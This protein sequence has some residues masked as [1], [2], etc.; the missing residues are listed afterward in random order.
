MDKTSS[1]YSQILKATSIFGGVQ[2][3]NI[4]T[5]VVRTKFVA[6]LLGPAGMG[7]VGLLSSTTDFG[8]AL[9]SFGLSTSA[10]R[11]V[12]EAHASANEDKIARTVFA[13]RRLVWITGGLG[14]LLV[15]FT[16]P[17]LSLLA[18]GHYDY[19]WAFAALSVTLLISQLSTGQQVLLQGFRK[20]RLLAKSGILASFASLIITVPLYY[21]F[22]E[23]GI[24]P[25]LLLL[26]ITGLLLSWYFARKI[27]I[28]AVRLSVKESFELG[29]HML[30]F[31]FF[32]SLSGLLSL[33]TAY[34]VRIYI[35]NTGGVEEVGFYNAGFAII[36][37]Y[38]GLVFTAMGTDYYPRLTGVIQD[39]KQYSTV[40]NEQMSVAFYLLGPILCWFIVFIKPTIVLLY[41]NQ[42][43]PVN[44]M[45][46][47]AGAGM[48]F[49]AMGWSLGFIMLAK[50]DTKFYFW[51]EF[52]ALIYMLIL[53]IIGYYSFGLLGLGFSF[54]VGYILYATQVLLVG[55]YRFKFIFDWKNA[56]TLL[57]FTVLVGLLLTLY[58]ILE[59][60]ILYYALGSGISLLASLYSIYWL[61]QK[62]Q[63]IKKI[64]AKFTRL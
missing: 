26:S 19:A 11:D 42:F 45:I 9:T 17:W 54:L 4:V 33:G 44:E 18:F 62:T 38:V 61:N 37:T 3:I 40:V 57:A 29:K 5:N 64:R 23:Q 20:I 36:N 63:A 31:G 10:V 2:V 58:Y 14:S 43:T 53:N 22:G 50:A 7:I 39:I 48:L 49:K 35:G 27:K 21:F 28:K 30:K 25:A 59:N 16:A 13:L 46:L 47:W 51:N 34:I 55:T 60:S 15:L 12:A 56:F 6:V 1:G 24:V 8:K 32:I 52:I 41:S